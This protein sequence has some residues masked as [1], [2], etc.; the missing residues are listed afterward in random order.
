MKLKKLIITKLLP[1]ILLFVFVSF[2]S[3]GQ[4]TVS[5]TV[6][7]DDGAG[8][9][10][11][12]VLVKGTTTGTMTDA[13]GKYSLNIPEGA[14]ILVFSYIGM[15]TQEKPIEGN[16]VDCVLLIDDSQLSEVI[17][18]G[19]GE[20][21]KEDATGSVQSVSSDDFNEGNISSPEDLLTGKI[22]GVVIT[23]SGGQPGGASTIRIRGGSSLNA[24]NDPLIVIDG[25]PVDN[26]GIG[27]MANPLSTI[28]P[29]DIESFTVLKDA[30]ATA[31]YGSRASNGVII[32]T[33]KRGHS[34][35][36]RIS[37][38]GNVSLGVPV[39]FIDVLSGD[40]YR[41][42]LQEK[43]DEG[44]VSEVALTKL[45][46]AN[47]DWQK[48]IYQ[49]AISHDHNVSFTGSAKQLPYRLSLG[50]TDQNG[51]LKY[52]EMK[53][54]T[55]DFSLNP[56][57]FDK[58]LKLDLNVKGAFTNNNFSNTGAIGAAVQFDPTQPIMNGNTA[59]GGYTAW[60]ESSAEDQLNG[61]PNNIATQNPVALLEFTD[62]TSKSQRYLGNAK[63][64]YVL[65]FMPELKA[66]VKGAYDYFNSEGHN[67]TDQKA[68][69]SYRE[70]DRNVQEYTN[71]RYTSLIDFYMNYNKEFGTVHKI[72][73]TGGYSWEHHYYEGTYIKHDWE[74]TDSAV[75][76][77]TSEY[78]NEYLLLSLFGR[79]NYTLYN[80]YLFTAT[81]RYDGSSR[82]APENRF[83]LFPSAAFAWKINEENFLKDVTV[84]SNLKLRLGWG[85]TGQQDIGRLYPYIP[86]YV[87]SQTGAYYQFGDKFYPTLR[88]DPYDPNIKWEETVT[89]NA[90][91]D[92]GFMNE[93]ITGS[94]DVYKR[95]TNDL[96]NDIPIP[97]G[98]NF[99]NHLI[100]NVGSLENSGVEASLTLRPVSEKNMSLEISGNFTYNVNKITKLTLV[101]DTAFTGYNVGGIAGG[102]GNTVQ[103]NQVGYPANT[104]Y[105]FQQVYDQ[106][107]MPIEGLYTDKTGN[108]GNVAGD[109]LNKYYL[110]NPAPQYLFGLSSRFSYKN[111][112]IA[113]SGRF[114]FGNYV[115]NNNA[116]NMALY[117]NLYNQSGYTAN[118]LSD[119]SKSNFRTAQ[120][121]SDFY[122]EN[123]SFFRMDYISAGYNFNELLTE[124]LSGRI[125]FTVQN[126]FVVTQYSGID[127]EV[128]G[129]IDNNIYPRP[130]T[131]LLGLNLNF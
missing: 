28:N 50:Y 38:N 63:A 115:Y 93:K 41:T 129:G 22:S 89:Q 62:N 18:I 53:R 45:G 92:F 117:Q 95:T 91:L 9:P 49:N 114:N 58:N 105:L 130:R 127:P 4:K 39:K 3:Y 66:V 110:Q 61:P 5:G 77:G 76:A 44:I 82:F 106:N 71:M 17:V 47:T 20:V 75:T 70:P 25:I 128:N 73:F 125:S 64:E 23:N 123:A 101:D 84:I 48:E 94:V 88:P 32:I 80:K 103:V 109:N 8:I 12:S 56:E 6:T 121:W 59:Y 30:S 2:A 100:T 120:Y 24:S 86:T 11:V 112:D 33:T 14:T 116:S 67:Y 16:V 98:T 51:L 122:L 102:V 119:V 108:G 40:E 126:A 21:K 85:K 118:I 99:S 27:G 31:I 90:G 15:K 87:L 1:A 113:F 54:S 131:Y 26:S 43:V 57:L 83:G 78:K 36:M 35:A 19:Y 10:G 7:G 107:G 46:D 37:Y 55:F 68:S 29:N 81:V 42:L 74:A 104:F 79:L 96:L 72:D 97:A 52:S 13:S 34:G 65:P 124:R 60:V 69:W 111:F